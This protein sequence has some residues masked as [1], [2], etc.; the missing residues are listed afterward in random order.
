MFLNG[1]QNYFNNTAV[2][3]DTDVQK[4]KFAV[5]YEIVRILWY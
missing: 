1:L 3:G 4:E 2:E 5:K